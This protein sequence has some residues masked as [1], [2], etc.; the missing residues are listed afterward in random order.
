MLI[1][2]FLIGLGSGTASKLQQASDEAISQGGW[3]FP[4][5]SNCNLSMC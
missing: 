3:S 4:S 1:L 5:D 2:F